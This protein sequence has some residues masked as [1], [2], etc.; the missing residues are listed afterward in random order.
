M[1]TAAHKIAENK[2]PQIRI[3]ESEKER[4]VTFYFNGLREEPSAGEEVVIVPSPKVAT[5]DKKIEMNL[6]GIVEKFHAALSS[7][8]YRFFLMN[9]A[10]ADMVAHSGSISATIKAI[11]RVDRAIGEV[12]D[13]ILSVN[14]TLIITSD[15]G[16]AEQVASYS[17]KGYFYTTQKGTVNTSHSS[18]PVPLFVIA[19]DLA[20]KKL[21]SGGSLADIAPI[22]LSRLN[23]AIPSVMTGKNLIINDQA[24]AIGKTT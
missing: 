16:N 15:H 12:A 14:G 20:G 13:A 8:T 5:Y 1:D 7:D 21:N 17:K 2:L 6:S 19:N 10:N 3:A 22:L 24:A 18:N 9:F 11:E 23:L 4:M